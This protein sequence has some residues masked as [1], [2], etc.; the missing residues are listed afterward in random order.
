M[1]DFR[2]FTTKSRTDCDG[3]I[4]GGVTRATTRRIASNTSFRLQFQ[5]TETVKYTQNRGPSLAHHE[6]VG[7]LGLSIG[8]REGALA[9]GRA[10]SGSLRCAGR[11]V[12]GFLSKTEPAWGPRCAGGAVC[13][14]HALASVPASSHARCRVPPHLQISKKSPPETFIP[15]LHT[16]YEPG[17]H[18][19]VEAIGF[20]TYRGAHRF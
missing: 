10:P 19:Q 14:W 20:I 6:Y 16:A 17:R 3:E 13:R 8:S 2:S 9:W 12:T 18:A 5:R 11:G 7:E 1:Q 4:F 15:L